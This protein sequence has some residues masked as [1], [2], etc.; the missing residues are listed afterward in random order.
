MNK[1]EA[2][3]A[4]IKSNAYE[5]SPHIIAYPGGKVSFDD[6]GSAH[7][8]FVQKA[9]FGILPEGI[10][11]DSFKE[12]VA[13]A[14]DVALAVLKMPSADL[15]LISEAFLDKHAVCVSRGTS[16]DGRILGMSMRPARSLYLGAYFMITDLPEGGL[17]SKAEPGIDE[18]A[19]NILFGIMKGMAEKASGEGD[20]DHDNNK[21]IKLNRELDKFKAM[22]DMLDRLYAGGDYF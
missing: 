1:S 22:R 19:K 13:K 2:I 21:Y 16:E 12:Q 14:R 10:T 11:P 8:S 6:A 18:Q 20:E 4:A 9:V 3:R 7:E 15:I 17:P 5:A